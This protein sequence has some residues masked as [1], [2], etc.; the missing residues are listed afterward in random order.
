MLHESQSFA[1]LL[2]HPEVRPNGSQFP[3]DMPTQINAFSVLEAQRIVGHLFDMVKI[4]DHGGGTHE[5]TAVPEHFLHSFGKS[6]A[7]GDAFNDF[8]VGQMVMNALFV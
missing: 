1:S 4:D 2:I 7:N 3:A 5:K 6:C 8:S